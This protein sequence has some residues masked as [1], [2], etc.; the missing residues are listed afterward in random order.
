MHKILVVSTLLVLHYTFGQKN[1]VS[2]YSQYGLGDVQWGVNGRSMAMGGMTLAQSNAL[3]FN[4]DN[5]ATLSVVEL[6]TF[7]LGLNNTV[8]SISNSQLAENI[9]NYS[10]NFSHIKFAVPVSKGQTLSFGFA[11]YSFIGYDIR[12]LEVNQDPIPN[13]AYRFTGSGGFS[14]FYI[15]FGSR[16]FKGLSLGI[17][18][19]YLFGDKERLN[20]ILPDLSNALNTR[21]KTNIRLDGL[22]YN[23]GITYSFKLSDKNELV[24]GGIF[25]PT[26][27]I[28]SR[29]E[30]YKISFS[31]GEFGNPVDTFGI[32]KAESTTAI[33]MQWGGGIS[34][35]RYSNYHVIPALSF[36]TE[37][38]YIQGSELLLPVE[39]NTW[40]NS[41]RYAIG[42]SAIPRFLIDGW[43]RST[44][45]FNR[46]EYRLGGFYETGLIAL[47]DKNI[48]QIGITFGLALPLR[49]RGLA[50][51]E[52]KYNHIS[53]GALVGR[54]GTTENNLIQEN[55]I[56][57]FFGVTLN[58]K[59][60][61]KYKYR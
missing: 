31:G 25:A 35:N 61:I 52:V 57:F 54:R 44:N 51:G 38:R 14:Q 55:F 20:L 33:P 1:S 43:E 46:L 19:R 17:S 32:S 53:I 41:F 6:T 8:Y 59:W 7:D 24:I 4:I 16:L 5:P 58:D 37:I 30:D 22:T 2:A 26:V 28:K 60:F 11:P 39:G 45:Y 10:T 34:F 56:R 27:A 15:G 47:N 42:A 21:N 50:P 29:Y 13:V 9:R 3:F 12:S 48:S 49:I 23:A 40:Q 18:A 36:G